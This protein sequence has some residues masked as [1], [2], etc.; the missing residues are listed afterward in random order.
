MKSHR[1]FHIQ[2]SP[3][4]SRV[5]MGCSIALG[6]EELYFCIWQHY[7]NSQR[8]ESEPVFSLPGTINT[9]IMFTFQNLGLSIAESIMQAIHFCIS[10]HLKKFSKIRCNFGRVT[11]LGF[12]QR[13]QRISSFTNHILNK[14]NRIEVDC[15]H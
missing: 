6:A 11:G 12:A 10:V 15:L 3:L 1:T 5:R 4:N 8:P 9:E 7:C 14:P 2:I 13:K